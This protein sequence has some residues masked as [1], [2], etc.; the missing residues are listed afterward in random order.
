MEGSNKKEENQ[1]IELVTLKQCMQ[2]SME[3]AASKAAHALREELVQALN[4][5]PRCK[6][7]ISL[8]RT[9]L[10]VPNKTPLSILHEYA[11]RLN[12]EVSLT[13]SPSSI[14]STQL[15]YQRSIGCTLPSRCI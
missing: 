3:D 1:G 5:Y 8:Y 15:E 4:P 14:T 7:L 6:H 2:D 13:W 9:A 11:T 10:K 12:L